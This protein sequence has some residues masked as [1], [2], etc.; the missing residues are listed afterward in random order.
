MCATSISTSSEQSAAATVATLK[1]AAD[2][3]LNCL[4]YCTSVQLRRELTSSRCRVVL[5]LKVCPTSAMQPRR[6][7]Y[8][9]AT[10]VQGTCRRPAKGFRGHADG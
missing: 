8:L 5:L 2:W 1:P 10:A 6:N 9:L 7:G 3:P 4:R